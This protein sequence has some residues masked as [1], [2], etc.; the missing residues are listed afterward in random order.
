VRLNPISH[1]PADVPG[2]V[3]PHQKQRRL[4]KASQ[5]R[6][7]SCTICCSSWVRVR[8]KSGVLIP[9]IYHVSKDLA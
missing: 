3:V 1:L 5:E 2:G 6:R 7:P 8:T 4:T 9:P